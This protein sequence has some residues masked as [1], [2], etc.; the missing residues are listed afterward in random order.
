MSNNKEL[1]D[2]AKHHQE[3]VAILSGGGYEYDLMTRLIKAL[4]AAPIDRAWVEDN[5]I[6]V[7]SW[8]GYAIPVATLTGAV[9][10]TKDISELTLTN[11]ILG[12]TAT[13]AAK[14]IKRYL[15]A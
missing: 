9:A 11:L 10:Q 7:D 3:R 4:E 5:K 13:Q 1:I 8:D 15:E 6:Y 2:E 12:K 14:D